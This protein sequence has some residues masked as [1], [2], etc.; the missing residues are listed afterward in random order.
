[1][2]DNFCIMLFRYLRF[3]SDAFY[4]ITVVNSISDLLIDILYKFEEYLIFHSLIILYHIIM[5]T[6]SSFVMLACSGKHSDWK[7]RKFP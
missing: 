3:V 6:V 4:H 1:M 5:M 2:E 7:R